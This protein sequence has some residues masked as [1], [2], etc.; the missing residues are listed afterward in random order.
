MIHFFLQ[1]VY[2]RVLECP[3]VGF[4]Y[5]NPFHSDRNDCNRSLYERNKTVNDSLSR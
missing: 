3:Y 1:E 4:W 2:R 5:R